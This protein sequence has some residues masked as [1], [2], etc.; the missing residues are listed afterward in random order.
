MGDFMAGEIYSMLIDGS[1]FTDG[2]GNA[3][4]ALTSGFTI[5]TAPLI[6]FM[7]VGTKHFDY[8]FF[9]GERYGSAA[10]VSPS[11]EVFMVG[12]KNGT[13][14][15]TTLLNDVWKLATNRAINCASS[16]GPKT[17]CS[18]TTCT[19][20][21][22]GTSSA[23]KTIWRAPSASGTKCMSSTGSMT[24]LGQI[25]AT[26]TENCPCPTC[27]TPPDGSLVANILDGGL[28]LNTSYTPVSVGGSLALNCGVGYTSN[29][30]SFSCVF[31][32]EYEGVF[33]TPYPTC[34]QCADPTCGEVVPTTTTTAG[35][36][37]TKAPAPPPA[38]SAAAGPATENITVYTLKASLVLDF[39][40]LPENVTAAELAADTTFVANVAS[41]IA[42]GLGVDPS[43]I[44]ITKIEVI[45]RRRL[46]EVALRQL[47]G[48]KLKIEYEMIT[49]SLAEATLVEETLADPTKSATFGAA[50]TAALVEKEA[51]SGRVVELKEVVASP[52]TVT[53]ETKLVVIGATPA[54]ATPAPTPAT[55]T[56]SPSAP[57]PTPASVAPTPS[58]TP[59]EESEEE[60][61][62]NGAVIGGAVGGVVG[63]G[64]LGG[65][66]YMYKKK[67]AQE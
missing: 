57:T 15:A 65:A 58:P 35:P 51:A 62:D 4:A 64:V 25:V 12:G 10:C 40:R 14:G 2:E 7:K 61:G 29:G 46:S 47:Q 37:T 33:A 49:T 50:F 56:P 38:T 39:G 52:A 1:A 8:S 23:T 45:S 19:G 60:E 31:S 43:K 36:V 26:R 27:A 22:L 16:Y 41:S 59:S 21:A 44:T 30:S 53:S 24:M 11:N 6:K 54:P 18:A 34:L 32:S 55:P 13:A 42:V 5:S 28:Y 66:A 3:M 20:G 9:N 17:D 48:P 67:S 63:L